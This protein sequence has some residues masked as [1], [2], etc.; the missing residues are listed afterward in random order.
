MTQSVKK[1]AI[2]NYLGTFYALVVGIVC[3]PLYLKYLGAEAYGL[4]GFFTVMQAWLGILDLGFSPT[5]SRQAAYARSKANGFNT[6]ADILKSFELLF[7]VLSVGIF[8]AMYV[9]SDIMAGNWF[10]A[11]EL[12]QGIIATAVIL[13]GLI[14][15]FRFQ[16]TL[17][18]SGIMGLEHQVW[19]NK[20]NVVF[21]S[22]KFVGALL[23]M[24]FVSADITHYFIYQTVIV[25]V[26]FLVI[27]IKLYSLL[28][29][30]LNLAPRFVWPQVKQILPFSLGIAY[31]ASLWVLVTQ[32]D[33]LIL[34]KVLPLAEYGYFAL[35]AVIAGG[36]LQLTSPISQAIQPRLT[37]LFAKGNTEQA[38]QLYRNSA[39]VVATI[40]FSVAVMLAVFAGPLIY[41]W[42][43]DIAAADWGKSVL[44]WFALG[45]AVLAMGAFQYYLQFAMGKLRLHVIG[46]SISA[47][48][49]LP[50]IAYAAIN[51]GA[52]G[53]GVA[54][55]SFRCLFFLIWSPIVHR[56][57]FPGLHSKWLFK[58]IMPSVLAFGLLSKILFEFNLGWG[59]DYS[60]F[61]IFLAISVLAIVVTFSGAF[62][63]SYIRAAF[64]KFVLFKRN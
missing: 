57:Y 64:C 13:M 31:T 56:S 34:S 14:V 30:G 63:S 61:T 3:L 7:A 32:L 47:A 16:S 54:W 53:A 1:N 45:N 33:K 41:A 46:S 37:L 42:S 11:N 28:P 35:V 48:L 51:Y 58:D 40:V 26:E 43:G 62:A 52:V 8:A 12:S 60:R 17:Y 25:V 49:Q 36:L 59:L 55:F 4:V 10:K 6:F 27:R 5:L 22:L 19:L 2:A 38:L 50:I 20:V 24:A 21:S 44:P 39:Q 29:E 9:C 23:F 18:R 15:A